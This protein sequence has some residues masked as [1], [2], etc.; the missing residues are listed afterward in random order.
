M[1]TGH[2]SLTGGQ[3]REATE[4]GDILIEPFLEERLEPATYDLRVGK[5]GATADATT[6]AE[7]KKG[8]RQH[9]VPPLNDGK[10]ES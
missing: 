4:S 6:R 3:I 7:L 10:E 2:A 5:Q 9:K 1:L 8:M